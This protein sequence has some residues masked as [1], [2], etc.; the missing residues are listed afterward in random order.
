M[1]RSTILVHMDDARRVVSALSHAE[2]VARMFDARLTGLYV[3]PA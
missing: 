2:R 3:Q 1:A